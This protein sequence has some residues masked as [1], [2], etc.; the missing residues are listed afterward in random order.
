MGHISKIQH[1]LGYMYMISGENWKSFV[2]GLIQTGVK[3]SEFHGFEKSVW[4]TDNPKNRLLILN[5][6][7]TITQVI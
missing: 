1:N 6:N 4:Y 7:I 2:K 5:S 3:K